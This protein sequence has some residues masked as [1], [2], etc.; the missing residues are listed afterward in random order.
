MKRTERLGRFNLRGFRDRVI[1]MNDH[2]HHKLNER[3]IRICMTALMLPAALDFDRAVD[4]FLLD[5]FEDGLALLDQV[6]AEHF[7]VFPAIVAVTLSRK[8]TLDVAPKEKDAGCARL[9][10]AIHRT[11]R[12]ILASVV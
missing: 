11:S 7:A 8:E 12:P 4:F 5:P 10:V 3:A 6:A 9:F 1:A 2:V